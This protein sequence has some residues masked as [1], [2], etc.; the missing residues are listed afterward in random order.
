MDFNQILLDFEKLKS[1]GSIHKINELVSEVLNSAEHDVI[2]KIELLEN[3]FNHFKYVNNQNKFINQ[4]WILRKNQLHQFYEQQGFLKKL[5]SS[6]EE[7]F[8]EEY[9]HLFCI[10]NL[11]NQLMMSYFRVGEIDKGKKILKNYFYYLLQRKNVAKCQ[12][13]LAGPIKNFI[14]EETLTTSHLQ[15]LSLQGAV[16]EIRSLLTKKI[17]KKKIDDLTR[18]YVIENPSSFS[19]VPEAQYIVLSEQIKM[20]SPQSDYGLIYHTLAALLENIL[21]FPFYALFYDLLLRLIEQTANK[22]LEVKLFPE[23]K[24]VLDSEKIESRD[25][26][27]FSL[28]DQFK[29][30]QVSHDQSILVSENTELNRTK[31]MRDKMKMQKNLNELERMVRDIKVLQQLGRFEDAYKKILELKNKDPHHQMVIEQLQNVPVARHSNTFIFKNLLLETGGK[32]DEINQNEKKVGVF[33]SLTILDQIINFIMAR[34]Y[35]MALKLIEDQKNY[36][37]NAKDSNTVK[38]LNFLE[39][40]VTAKL[41]R[42]DFDNFLEEMLKKVDPDLDLFKRIMEMVN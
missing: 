7:I 22:K 12:E 2:Q 6:I 11:F 23:I 20:L 14:D 19:E 27:Q 32:N 41:N 17:E 35:Q 25:L 1:A 40:F 10:G 21:K 42:K 38:Q 18:N 29:S 3:Y 31:K 24:L 39:I 5:I 8:N 30:T 37:M 16:E 26:G 33:S 34:E 15:I 28:I 9:A 36:S 13:L 4:D